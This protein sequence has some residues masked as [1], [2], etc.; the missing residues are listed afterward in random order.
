MNRIPFAQELKPK[1]SLPERFVLWGCATI[2]V[3]AT[4]S[5]LAALVKAVL[6]AVCAVCR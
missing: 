5:L 3:L 4:G 2:T 6:G 1:P